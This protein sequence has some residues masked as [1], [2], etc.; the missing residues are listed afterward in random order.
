MTLPGN[1]GSSDSHAS[2][3]GQTAGGVTVTY[4]GPV[5]HSGAGPTSGPI[6]FRYV[7]DA[8]PMSFRCVSDEVFP[9]RFRSVSDAFPMPFGSLSDAFQPNRQRTNF[10]YFNFTQ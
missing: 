7:S 5:V 9:M 1:M 2:L 10:R 8:F 6:P 4:G 3:A